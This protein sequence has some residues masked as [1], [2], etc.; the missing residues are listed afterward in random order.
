LDTTA[1]QRIDSIAVFVN[2]PDK[3]QIQEVTFVNGLAKVVLNTP[4]IDTNWRQLF[5]VEGIWKESLT[6][7]PTKDTLSWWIAPE[8][9]VKQDIGVS[10]DGYG[11]SKLQ[12]EGEPDKKAVQF[13][14]NVSANL[15][16]GENV[17]VRFKQ[18]LLHIDTAKIKLLKNEVEQPF[19][20]HQ[21]N[22][23][24]LVVNALF[25]EGEDYAIDAVQGAFTSIYESENDSITL[26]F[27]VAANNQL[28]AVKLHLSGPDFDEPLGNW[29]VLLRQSDKTMRREILTNNSLR[30]VFFEH[31][32]PGKYEISVIFD[33]NGNG[34]WDTGDYFKNYFPERIVYYPE[35]VDVRKGWD[36]E[37]YWE[38]GKNTEEKK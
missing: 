25:E 4:L 17:E 28:G 18:P 29:I 15:N 11:K 16:P 19:T 2:L 37:L 33:D 8:I 38:L 32:T 27:S 1:L 22:E 7:N 14:T 3:K 23:N 6:L 10:I 34:I 36:V 35:M 31:L 30:T 9:Y 12:I 20:V 21:K 24:T 13:T 5:Q 26:L